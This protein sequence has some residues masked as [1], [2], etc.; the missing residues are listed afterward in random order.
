MACDFLGLCLTRLMTF[1]CLL[2]VSSTRKQLQTWFASPSTGSVVSLY[3][4][5]IG[6]Y[7]S[8]WPS[9]VFAAYSTAP[10]TPTIRSV[11]SL[12]PHLDPLPGLDNR[13]PNCQS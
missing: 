1:T 9:V 3:S 13:Y 12:A 2:L 8:P 10:S 4:F 7:L 11:P 5:N 6:T